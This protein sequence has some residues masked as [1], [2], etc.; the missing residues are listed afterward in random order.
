MAEGEDGGFGGAASVRRSSI[1]GSK[2]KAEGGWQRAKTEGRRCCFGGAASVLASH[3]TTPELKVAVCGDQLLCRIE[4]HLWE[5]DT[6]LSTRSKW[7]KPS[8]RTAV[9]DSEIS[10]CI[11][12]YLIKE[13]QIHLYLSRRPCN[14][15]AKIVLIPAIRCP[16]SPIHSEFQCQ[17]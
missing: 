10:P 2:G 8:S 3:G 4:G 14:S 12:D 15:I 13:S 6:R 7:C 16:L 9:Q 11:V 5:L 17:N 1:A